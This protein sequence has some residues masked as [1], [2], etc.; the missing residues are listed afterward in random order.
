MGSAL[1]FRDVLIHHF[2]KQVTVLTGDTTMPTNLQH[3]P[4]TE[5]VD[6]HPYPHIELDDIDLFLILD[7]AARSQISRIEDVKFPDHMKTICIDHHVTNDGYAD[8]NWIDGDYPATTQMLFDLF[9]DWGVDLSHDAALNL[10]VGMFTDTGGFQY[11]P[12]DHRTLEAAA[13][14]A[15]KA[16]DYPQAIFAIQNTMS[17]EQLFYQGMAL[18]NI[19]LFHEETIAISAVSKDE[20]AEFGIHPDQADKSFIAN[21]LKAVVGWQVAVGMV[22]VEP[23]VVKASFRTRDAQKY[24]VGEIAAALGGGGHAAAAGATLKSSLTDAKRLIVE[25]VLAHENKHFQD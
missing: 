25:A 21:H 9:Q 11:P 23:N 8:I 22:E 16:P 5:Y 13:Q 10:F 19:E 12:V 15:K 4:G 3:L 1:A 24:H 17:R 6:P 2:D 18:K 20:L 14:L 7:S